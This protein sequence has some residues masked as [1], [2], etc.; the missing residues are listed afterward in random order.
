LPHLSMPKRGPKCKLGYYRVFNL[1]LW[2]LYTGC[3]FAG[4]LAVIFA[5]LFA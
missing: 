4:I 1:I 3:N 5:L 2:V